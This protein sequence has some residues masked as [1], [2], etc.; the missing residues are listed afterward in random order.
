MW[1]V[2]HIAKYLVLLLSFF[3]SPT[4]VMNF[5]QCWHM[6]WYSEH[7]V[8]SCVIKMQ[9]NLLLPPFHYTWIHFFDNL[10]KKNFA[11][12]WFESLTETSNGINE[13][14][15]YLNVLPHTKRKLNSCCKLISQHQLGYFLWY[16]IFSY[17]LNHISFNGVT[18]M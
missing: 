15:C 17:Q 3:I 13:V 7:H 1:G 8:Y 16:N 11:K 2:D 5:I 9:K 14:S 4:N 12:I 18:F 6:L 10:C